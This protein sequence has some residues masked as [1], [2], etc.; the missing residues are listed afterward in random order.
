MPRS[1]TSSSCT[2]LRKHE[3]TTDQKVKLVCA[4]MLSKFKADKHF[5]KRDAQK[6]CVEAM[7]SAGGKANNNMIG[8]DALFSEC[9]T[10]KKGYLEIA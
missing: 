5:D 6:F 2:N 4:N 8:F 1:E 7:K 10:K 9:D 3:S